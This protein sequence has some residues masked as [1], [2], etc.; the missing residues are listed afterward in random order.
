MRGP[1]HIVEWSH[2]SDRTANRDWSSPVRSTRLIQ[3][4]ILLTLATVACS[5]ASDDE[6]DIERAGSVDAFSMQV[7][8]CFDDS[9]FG[10]DEISEVAGVRCADEH[11]NEVYA[12][13]DIPGDTWPGDD[14]VETA[15]DEG[16]YERFES[17]IGKSYEESI[18]MYTTL[19]PSKDSWARVDDR[20]VICVA[21]H[22]ET[23]KLT[24]SVL[25]SG[26]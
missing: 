20:E 17:A 4:S 1:P 3:A 2:D 5:A 19:Y 22:M 11:D 14:A 6:G 8:D 9:F 23:E 13:F 25:R 12:L 18:L 26:L 10:S 15:A 21:Y 24:G 16:C 7:G